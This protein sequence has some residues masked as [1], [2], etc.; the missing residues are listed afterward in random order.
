ML[1][2]HQWIRSL[3]AEL[4][5]PLGI[6]I[7]VVTAR[8]V[9]FVEGAWILGVALFAKQTRIQHATR[10]A[11]LALLLALYGALTLSPLIGRLRPFVADPLIHALVP[12]PLS[13]FSF[14]SAHASAAFAMAFAILWT[15][16]RRGLVPLVLAIMVAFGR[17]AVGVHYPSDVLAGC[18]V[19]ALAAFFVRVMHAAVRR[20]AWYQHRHG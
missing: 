19:G 1:L 11:G 12:H 15:D 2:E 17:V 8:W 20:T 9:I 4:A 5:S 16:W 3:Q 7:S 18:V 14:P 10:E 13:Q 6:W